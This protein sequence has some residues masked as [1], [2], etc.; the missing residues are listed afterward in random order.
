MVSLPAIT[1]CLNA[2][3][4]VQTFDKGY[5]VRL[6]RGWRRKVRKLLHSD[7]EFPKALWLFFVLFFKKF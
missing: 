6:L 3:E 7:G 4:W 1:T 2:Q 5:G